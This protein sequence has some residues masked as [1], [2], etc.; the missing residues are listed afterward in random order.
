MKKRCFVAVFALLAAAALS[1]QDAADFEYEAGNG[2]ITITGYTGSAKDVTIPERIDNL[3]VTVI[4]DKAFTKNQLTSVTIGS[5]VRIEKA[6][7]ST[8]PRPFLGN[9]LELYTR[10]GSRAGTHKSGDGGTTWR[11]E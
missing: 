7:F 8:E 2:A 3:P 6:E 10:E 1:G 5:N 11:S 9:L 4:G